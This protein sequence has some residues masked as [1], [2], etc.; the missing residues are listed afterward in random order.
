MRPPFL[1][2]NSLNSFISFSSSNK[3]NGK[4]KSMNSK[5]EAFAVLSKK[6]IYS[7]ICT[8]LVYMKERKHKY[9]LIRTVITTHGSNVGMHCIFIF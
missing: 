5:Q 7:P 9:L 8:P 2:V 3:S 6:R 4:K 1:V